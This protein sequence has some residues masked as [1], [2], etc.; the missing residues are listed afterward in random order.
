MSPVEEG[1]GQLQCVKTKVY[2]IAVR[3]DQYGPDVEMRQG[4]RCQAG[5]GTGLGLVP[6]PA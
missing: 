1:L 3:N 2:Q 5:R 6:I 4:D